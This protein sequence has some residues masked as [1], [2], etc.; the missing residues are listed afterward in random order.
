[1]VLVAGIR[2]KAAAR[3]NGHYGAFDIMPAIVMKGNTFI[4]RQVMFRQ[5][6]FVGTKLDVTSK[7]S[8]LF[9]LSV[10]GDREKQNDI[11][12]N[13]WD[14]GGSSKSYHEKMDS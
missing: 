6:L 2:Q 13:D 4:I 9:I 3:K 8:Q 1:M 12:E 14:S 5:Y 10:Y 11:Y 7:Y